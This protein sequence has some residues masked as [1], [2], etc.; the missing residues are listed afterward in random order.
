MIDLYKSGSPICHNP[1]VLRAIERYHYKKTTILRG[2]KKTDAKGKK[3][4]LMRRIF[5]GHS[6]DEKSLEAN[7]N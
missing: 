6:S 7:G 2:S 4:T 3:Q 5:V 1:D